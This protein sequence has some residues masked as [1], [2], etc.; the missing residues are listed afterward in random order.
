[1]HLGPSSGEPCPF[2]L[3]P[4]NPAT[5]G[6]TASWVWKRGC[7]QARGRLHAGERGLLPCE[8]RETGC[9]TREMGC[10]TTQAASKAPR[11]W[12]SCARLPCPA[13]ALRWHGEGK[14]KGFA[15][16]GR[17]LLGR[18]EGCCSSP[19]WWCRGRGCLSCC[20]LLSTPSSAHDRHGAGGHQHGQDQPQ[21]LQMA[22]AVGVWGTSGLMEEDVGVSKSG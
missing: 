13:A 2:R 5:L 8:T 20:A 6:K 17:A 18:W 15:G 1:M 7:Q 10:R 19:V 12:P 16:E 22:S 21:A 14:A 9:K 11:R 4:I 3:E